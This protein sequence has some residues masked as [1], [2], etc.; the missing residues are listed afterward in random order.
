MSTETK[1]RSGVWY[2]LLVLLSIIGGVIVY[3]VIKDDDPKNAKNC[4]Y[5]GIVLTVIPIALS[6][7][8]G[9]IG[10]TVNPMVDF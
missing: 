6:I 2:L 5:L 8:I 7:I 4:L 10:M 9:S 3:F 1:N